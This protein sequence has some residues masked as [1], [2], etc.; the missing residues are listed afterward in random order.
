MIKLKKNITNYNKK[1]Y[2][3]IIQREDNILHRL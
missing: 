3:N 2:E 1:I